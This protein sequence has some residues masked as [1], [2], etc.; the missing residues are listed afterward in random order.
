MRK[1]LKITGIS[2]L[3]LLLLLFVTPYLFKGK[4]V[5]LVK[6]EINKSVNAKVDFRDVS[7]SLFRHFPKLTVSLQGLSV[8]GLDAFRGDTLLSAASFDASLN[9]VSAIRGKEMKVYGVYLN[10]PRIRALVNKEGKAS[11]D[12]AKPDTAATESKSGSFA[13][14][15]QQYA[16][17]DGYVYYEDEVG[18]MKAEVAGLNHEGSGAFTQE[19]F[20]LSTKTKATT[21]SFNYGGVPYLV[22]AETG[23]DAD[24]SIDNGKRRYAVQQTTL[25]VN[26]LKLLANGFVQIDNDSSYTMDLSFNAPSNDF[27][28]LL[29]LVPAI[30]KNEFGKLKTG[31]TAAFSGF[32]KGSY[33]PRQLP[34]YKVDLQVK[35]GF[36]QYPDLPQPVQH[37][38]IAMQLSN[39]DGAPDHAVVDIARGHLE[40]A[41][42]PLD[43]KLLFRNPMTTKYLD[44]VVKGK[45]NLSD[46]TKFVK[47]DGGT[48]LSGSVWADAFAKGS[49][50]ALQ[51]AGGA[52]VAG[53]FFDVRN[54]NYASAAL[55]QPVRNGN[56]KITLRN[57]GGVADATTVAVDP[58]HIEVGG[59]P[60]DFTLQLAHPVSSVDF[61]GTAKGRFTLDNLKQFMKLEPGTAVKGTLDADVKFAGSKAAVDK[62]EYE[63]IRTEGTV[64]LANLAYTSRE[65]PEGVQVQNAQFRFNPQNVSMPAFAG[66][67]KGSSLSA[68]GVLNNVIGYALRNEPLSG[69]LNV[70]ADRL[71]LND[72][73]GTDTAAKSASASGPFAVPANLNLLLNA[74]AGEVD[75]DKVTYRNVQGSV[76]IKDEAVRLQ[77]VNME[78]LGGT[79][80][81]SGAY[82]T[83][84]SKTNPAIAFSYDVRNL[85]VQKAFYAFNTVQKLMPV[86]QALAGRLTSQFSI[87]GKLKDDMYPELNSLTG[88]GSMLLLEGV[89]N[90]FAPLEKLASTLSVAELKDISLKD[91]KTYFEFSNG[92]VL[93]KPFN[94]KVKD[95]DLQIGGM[96]GLDQSLDYLIGLKVPRKYLG[97]QG[98]ALVN[99][100]SVQ[101]QSR[102]IPVSLS[103]TIDFNVK[104][105]GTVSSPSLKTDLKQTTGDMAAQ[106]K[107]QAASFVQQKADSARQTLKDSLN[108]VKN[109][110]IEDTKNN[111]LKSLTGGKDSAGKP[112]S[113]EDT[114][115]KATETIKNTLGNLFG[116]KKAADTTRKD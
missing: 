104:M 41:N 105:G 55:P 67:F 96:H 115:N 61:S 32:V 107:Q 31:G 100:L 79:L 10:S 59:D 109:Q 82:S 15:L 44:A 45:L 85:D 14:S 81:L 106:L 78:A 23:V 50:S 39:P 95:I 54:F 42:E 17:R 110:V 34:A 101:A 3:T 114:K 70:T 38:N 111:L 25:T 76:L 98:N 40:M 68:S 113:F 102:G 92:K 74:R 27:K 36:F 57:E 72:W 21:A 19:L 87:T 16:I 49:L 60:F 75:Y 83:Q 18:G 112:A 13:L 62:K 6:A 99:N 97:A 47:L 93:V 58:G 91:I 12:I 94:V 64:N 11:W 7:L 51:Q 53:G 5:A 48:K 90:K 69:N 86:G 8:V 116:K 103:E 89:L 71:N 37:I 66:R 108:V 22:N 56:F 33:S 1:F 2:L 9:L 43:F 88:S 84:Q 52:F 24:I 35:D 65:Y 30:Y 28:D 63:K 26:S 4:I 46:V 77:N 29:S 80:A 20:T 73:M